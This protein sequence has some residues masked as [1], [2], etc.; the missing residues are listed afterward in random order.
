MEIDIVTEGKKYHYKQ[1]CMLDGV[2]AVRP[3]SFISVF[4]A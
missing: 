4:A 2:T 1:I 3:F